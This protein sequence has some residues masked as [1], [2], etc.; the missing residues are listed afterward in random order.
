MTF[1]RKVPIIYKE[2]M[3]NKTFATVVLPINVVVDSPPN[4]EED[5]VYERIIETAYAAL[6]PDLHPFALNIDPK[7][8][9]NADVQD[10]L[11][12]DCSN[13]ELID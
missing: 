9:Q 3:N 5:E 1:P 8:A 7:L 10:L 12:T 11:V 2:I 4:S 13:P 6:P